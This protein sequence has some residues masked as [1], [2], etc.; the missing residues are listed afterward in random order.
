MHISETEFVIF[1]TETTGL[2]PKQGDRMIE[3]GA[4]K[5]KGRKIIELL[6]LSRR[7]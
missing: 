2:S 1:D 5:V 7:L 4:V 6:I 3:L